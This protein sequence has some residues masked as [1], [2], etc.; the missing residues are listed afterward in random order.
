M[1]NLVD[2][3]SDIVETGMFIYRCVIVMDVS[4][5]I[6]FRVNRNQLLHCS[7][8]HCGHLLQHTEGQ[9]SPASFLMPFVF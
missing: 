4:R 1:S 7:E 3:R 2:T 9:K 8:V 5:A 6:T